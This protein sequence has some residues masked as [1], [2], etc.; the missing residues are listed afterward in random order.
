MRVAKGVLQVLFSSLASSYR[1][2]PIILFL[3]LAFPFSM[4]AQTS[5][6]T[7]CSLSFGTLTSVPASAGVSCQ[8]P[9][10]PGDGVSN[11]TLVDSSSSSSAF[12]FNGP[13][14]VSGSGALGLSVNFSPSAIGSYTGTVNATYTGTKPDGCQV[15]LA[16]TIN[17]DGAYAQAGFVNP[18]YVVIGV[19]YAPP[20]AQ[21]SVTY[22]N[23]TVAGNSIS[24]ASYFAD[25]VNYSVAL[26]DG[27]SISGFSTGQ[28]GSVSSS[29]TQQVDTAS[30]VA[31]LQ[32][33]S[34]SMTLSGVADPN[35]INHD[36]D[37]IFVWLNPILRFSVGPGPTQVQWNGYG[38]DVSDPATPDMD[39]IGIPVGCLNGD[40][41]SSAAWSG[42]CHD[43]SSGPLARSWAQNNVDGSGPAL[44]SADMAS[45]LAAD[46]F[47]NSGYTLTLASGSNTTADGR[48]TACSNPQCSTTVDFEPDL[49][50]SYSQG[51]SVTASTSQSVN[52]AYSQTFALQSQFQGTDFANNFNAD[53]KTSGTLTSGYQFNQFTNNSQGQTASFTIV[54]PSPGYAG[55]LQF[56]VY[57]D[58]LYGTFMFSPQ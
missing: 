33:T 55:P 39:V 21:S 7:S 38:S 18:K 51:Y 20:G 42:T 29:F 4:K 48:F 52:Y 56:V 45:I 10:Y 17:L 6:S 23:N 54:G 50:T 47:S 32:T 27:T 16:V 15:T 11:W 40:F 49:T 36:Y 9:L 37:Y 34:R 28:T 19:M 13:G 24:T 2:L 22:G 31:I 3:L 58:N 1:A 30:S 43:I 25:Q 41:S 35:G 5:A 44:T 57:Q 46:P 12:I 8:D 53:L 14:S 26:T